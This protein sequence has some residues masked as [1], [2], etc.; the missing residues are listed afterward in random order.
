[1]F[2]RF[3][4]LFMLI[5]T[6]SIGSGQCA[7]TSVP[8]PNLGQQGAPAVLQW[9]QGNTAAAESSWNSLGYAR[10]QSPGFW[11][12]ELI[13]S[14]MPD[15]FAN[16]NVSNDFANIPPVQTKY[17]NTSSPF[18][19]PGY[20][21][22]GDLL[23][24]IN[25]LDYLVDLGVTTLWITPVLLNSGGE[26]HGY[27]PSDLTTLDPNFGTWAD[28]QRLVIE[29]HKRG[30]LVVQDIVINH[31]CSY[32]SSYSQGPSDHETCANTLNGQFWGGYPVGDSSVQGQLGFSSLFWPPMQWEYFF[33]RCG[34]NS[35][36]DTSG[37]GP[38]AVYGD[39]VP[40][41]FDLATVCSIS[42]FFLEE[43]EE[44]PPT[45]HHCQ[46]VSTIMISKTSSQNS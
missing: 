25:R 15:R 10:Q 27:C 9:A 2:I 29:A 17:M 22:G 4:A 19:L 40:T 33:N 13:Y 36:S 45:T 43:E 37:E 46:Y 5:A 6:V 18:G 12:A 41:M 8:P 30:L 1:M 39:F 21:H 7:F 31:L 16:G 38:A 35:P 20:R 23:G 14:I 11:G 34:P 28:M 3:L 26:Y 44:K 24:I 42:I 32:D